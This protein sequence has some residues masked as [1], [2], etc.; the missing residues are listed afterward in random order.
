M[1]AR[2]NVVA[3]LARVEAGFAEG[4][5]VRDLDP[6]DELHRQH[7]AGRQV[8]VHDRDVDLL[9]PGHRRRRA[10]GRGRPRSGSRAPRGRP[11]ANSPTIARMPIWRASANRCSAVFASSCMTPR[12]AFVFATIR[13]RWTLTATSVP[14]ASVARWTWAVDAA[15]NGCSSIVANSSSGGRPSSAT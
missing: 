9:E 1:I 4:V 2:M 14:S 6:L 15:A 11:S 10:D 3:E 7:A 5:G 13:G 8:L 12:S